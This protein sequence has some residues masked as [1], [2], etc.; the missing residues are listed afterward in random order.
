MKELVP[1]WARIGAK[2]VLSQLPATYGFWRRVNLFRH[3]AMHRAEYALRVFDMHFARSRVGAG[4]SFTALELGPGDSLLSAIVAAGRGCTYLYLID[5][6]SFATTDMRVYHEAVRDLRER[7]LQPPDI[8]SVRDV[9]SMLAVCK[10]KYGT[11]GLASLRALPDASVDFMWS[12]A[13]LEHVR[14]AEFAATARE[15]RRV[16]RPQGVCSHEI[17]LRDHLGGSLNNMRIPSRWWE[18]DSMARSGF[19]T[20]RLRKREMI[21][22][23]L[24]AGFAVDIVS[25]TR[26]DEVP[27]ER[28]KLAR[29]FQ[30]LSDEDM[31]VK[32][33]HVVL[34]P[35]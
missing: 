21:E 7:G 13:V 6:G 32:T 11:A 27:V 34:T 9:D 23:F 12:N 26:W 22:D 14:R 5:A 20:N 17:D 3:G 16:L 19:Y 28:A 25:Q 18:K 1:W 33:F 24:R 4:D 30:Q 2:V 31:L 8:S 35:V 10:A 15:M 29:E